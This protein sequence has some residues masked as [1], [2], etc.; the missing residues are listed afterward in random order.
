MKA[1]VKENVIAHLKEIE[2]GSVG[3]GD[4]RLRV[5]TCG[6][7]GTEIREDPT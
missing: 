2:L 6:V 4:G 7:S 3:S 1:T 5:T